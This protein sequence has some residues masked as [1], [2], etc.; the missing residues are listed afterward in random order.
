MKTLPQI[1]ED[2]LPNLFKQ[3]TIHIKDFNSKMSNISIHLNKKESF[4]VVKALEKKGLAEYQSGT[5]RLIF[6]RI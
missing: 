3:N 2:R 1:I 6:K 4:E 5:G